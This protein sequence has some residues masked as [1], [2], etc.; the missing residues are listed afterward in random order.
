MELTPFL[1][2]HSFLIKCFLGFIGRLLASKA[3][4][5]FN[6]L[7][8]CYVIIYPLVTRIILLSSDGSIH[9][10]IGLIVSTPNSY[11]V[12]INDCSLMER[13]FRVKR[14]RGS[15]LKSPLFIQFKFSIDD[16]VPGLCDH[17]D[18][19]QFPNVHGVRSTHRTTVEINLQQKCELTG[20]DVHWSICTF[21]HRYKCP[22]TRCVSW[23]Q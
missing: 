14:R 10:S 20:V 5:P 11:Y 4:I 9:L 22:P 13:A 16:N 19:L 23:Q 17:H 3:L 2:N 15:L 8:N 6:K 1:S 18:F 7:T 21:V 12:S